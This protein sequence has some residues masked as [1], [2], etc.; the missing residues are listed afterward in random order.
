MSEA[1]ENLSVILL[2]L[3]KKLI[4]LA[5]VLF[6]GII[7]SF[8]FTAPIINRMKN[9]LLPEGAK[10]IYVSPLEVMMLELKISIIIG[11]LITLPLIAFYTYRIISL[12][13]TQLGFR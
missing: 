9:D 12:D 8:Q 4:V 2:G 1:I 6:T 10:L 7:I 13:V 11:L 5:V 3:R